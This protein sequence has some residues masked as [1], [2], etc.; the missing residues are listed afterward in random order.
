MRAAIRSTT[1]IPNDWPNAT[2]FLLDLKDK[3]LITEEEWAA[4]ADWLVATHFD[5]ANHLAG[6]AAAALFRDRA[7]TAQRE[8]L[9]ARLGTTPQHDQFRAIMRGEPAPPIRRSASKASV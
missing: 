7:T 3:P 4:I 6:D 9:A 1:N 2:M 8:E 5:V